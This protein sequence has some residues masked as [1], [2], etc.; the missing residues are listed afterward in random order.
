MFWRPVISL[1]LSFSS[2]ELVESKCPRPLELMCTRAFAKAYKVTIQANLSL[3]SILF[4]CY[5]LCNLKQYYKHK[6]LYSISHQA[7]S[8]LVSAFGLRSACANRWYFSIWISQSIPLFVLE[9]CSVSYILKWVSYV[10]FIVTDRE[11]F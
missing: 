8:S 4:I 1:I 10:E 9:L 6:R 2:I 11:L 3:Q 5:Q 7:I